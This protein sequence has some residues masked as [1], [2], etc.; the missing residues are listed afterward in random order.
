MKR[1]FKIGVAGSHS[2]GKTTFVSKMQSMIEDSGLRV[3][4][5][6]D[7][8]TRAL[9]LGFPIL[10][11]HTYESTLWIMAECMRQE[12]ELS[13]STDV[14]LVD[15]PALDALGYLQAALSVSGRSVDAGRLDALEQIAEAHSADY[16]VLVVTSLDPTIPVGPGR[17]D[18][19]MFRRAA[20]KAVDD[21]ILRKR[22][23]ALVLTSENSEEVAQTVM[24]AISA[25][26]K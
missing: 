1:P 12:A 4:R 23:D 17:D 24:T 6:G 26:I 10:R 13:L 7:I 20:A 15:R 8:A 2:T 19:E 3:G 22:C 16:D 11:K 5:V 25:N 9:K 14:I 18:D 21:L